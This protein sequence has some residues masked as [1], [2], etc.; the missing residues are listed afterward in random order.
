LSRPCR[1]Q[2]VE[3][4]RC[5]VSLGEFRV[6]GSSSTC[7]VQSQPFSTFPPSLLPQLSLGSCLLCFGSSLL[8]YGDRDRG[9][10]WAW[11]PFHSTLPPGRVPMY[12]PDTTRKGRKRR[13]RRFE[14]RCGLLQIAPLPPP[15]WVEG[16]GRG[17]IKANFTQICFCRDHQSSSAHRREDTGRKK[18][19]INIIHSNFIQFALSLS[20]VSLVLSR[21]FHFPTVHSTCIFSLLSLRKVPYLQATCA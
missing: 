15:R 8:A 14:A 5:D 2:R 13:R 18:L 19:R 1:S 12:G 21:F 7:G 9:R 3:N 11:A 10:D 16:G 20:L 4:N 17:G 6:S